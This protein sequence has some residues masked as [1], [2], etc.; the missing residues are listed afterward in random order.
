[1]P[2]EQSGG[3]DHGDD[4]KPK[5]RVDKWTVI[6]TV[7]GLLLLSLTAWEAFKG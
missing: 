5:R 1:M 4:P 3:A 2:P 7:T 6:Q